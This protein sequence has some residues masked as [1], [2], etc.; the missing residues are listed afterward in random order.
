MGSSLGFG[1]SVRLAGS[2][3]AHGTNAPTVLPAH[4]AS[5]RGYAMLPRD[6]CRRNARTLASLLGIDDP[7]LLPCLGGFML[8]ALIAWLWLG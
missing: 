1:G 8:V 2:R 7:F 5:D 4:G 6:G 3:T